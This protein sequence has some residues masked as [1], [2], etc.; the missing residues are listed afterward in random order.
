MRRKTSSLW[1]E[2]Q[3]YE[4]KNLLA[5]LYLNGV[6]YLSLWPFLIQKLISA[7]LAVN[8]LNYLCFWKSRSVY[9]V[10]RYFFFCLLAKELPGV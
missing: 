7:P 1:L 4:F 6:V 2:D 5:S 8:I 10:C 3:L 9:K